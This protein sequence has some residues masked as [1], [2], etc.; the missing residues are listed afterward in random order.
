MTVQE[1]IE[2][3]NK[4]REKNDKIEE[5][6]TNNIKVWKDNTAPL[7][8]SISFDFKLDNVNAKIMMDVHA[9]ALAFRQNIAEEIATFSNKRIKESIKLKKAT[10]EKMIWYLM[11]ESPLKIDKKLSSGQLTQLIDAYVSEYQRSVDLIDIHI[12]ALRTIAKDLMDLGFSVNKIVDIYNIIG[13][14]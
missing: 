9:G 4:L 3:L 2:Y 7:F 6:F 12:E 10:Q 8:N 14:N 1:E 11:G 5:Y 13:R